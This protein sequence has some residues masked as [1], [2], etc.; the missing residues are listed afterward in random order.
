MPLKVILRLLFQ[1]KK[2]VWI[3]GVIVAYIYYWKREENNKPH[4]QLGIMTLF[5]HSAIGFV[6]LCCV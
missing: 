1:L 6:F 5:T 3:L 2:V 4:V